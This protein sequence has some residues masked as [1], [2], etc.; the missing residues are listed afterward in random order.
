MRDPR[1]PIFLERLTLCLNLK[2]PNYIGIL[3]K[4]AVLVARYERS[5]SAAVR[6]VDFDLGASCS[7]QNH[8]PQ[9][10]STKR[11][12]RSAKVFLKSI[13]IGRHEKKGGFRPSHDVVKV[14][15]IADRQL[16]NTRSVQ[17]SSRRRRL[18]ALRGPQPS[19]NQQRRESRRPWGLFSHPAAA[20]FR[21]ETR[22][23]APSSPASTSPR[24]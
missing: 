24:L 4:R 7:R 23:S 14:P 12:N 1:R 5:A 2:P 8:L 13:A 22:C 21:A 15:G 17:T 20:A 19:P 16:P 9:P 11:L 6:A 10:K 18:G 3:C